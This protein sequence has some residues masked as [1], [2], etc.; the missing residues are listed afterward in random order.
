MVLRWLN[1][2]DVAI[3]PKSVKVERM[4]ENLDIF[5]FTLDVQDLAD[6]ATLNRNEM[7]FDHRNPKMIAWLAEFR[8]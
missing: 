7:I 8:G 1:Q 6:I 3:I 4:I 2:R 5:G